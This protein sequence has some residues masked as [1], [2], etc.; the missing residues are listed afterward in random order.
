MGSF[1]NANGPIPFSPPT[2][3]AVAHDGHCFQQH[4]KEATEANRIRGKWYA[5]L[6]DGGTESVS[7]RLV[8]YD[9][10]GLLI[11]PLVD[12]YANPFRSRSGVSILCEILPSMKLES[13]EV[14]LLPPI[15]LSRFRKLPVK[16]LIPELK[17]SLRNEDWK[18]IIAIAEYYQPGDSAESR[19]NCIGLHFLRTMKRLAE[20]VP[21]HS[22]PEVGNLA[23][24]LI[25]GSILMLREVSKIDEAAAPFQAA[26]LPILCAEIPGVPTF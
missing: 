16:T 9:R 21:E 13:A 1:A 2:P 5:K 4:M 6:S 8:L 26:G 22:E 15:E 14:N 19:F 23:K 18:S 3:W 25:R 17:R 24:A 10:L 12:L 20:V 7:S 11:T